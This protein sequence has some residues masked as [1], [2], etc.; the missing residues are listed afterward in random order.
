M[1]HRRPKA[2]SEMTLLVRMRH[3]VISP[4][5]T[6]CCLRRPLAAGRSSWCRKRLPRRR[7][8]RLQRPSFHKLA[9]RRTQRQTARRLRLRRRDGLRNCPRELSRCVKGLHRWTTRRS[10]RHRACPPHRTSSVRR[11]SCCRWRCRGGKPPAGSRKLASLETHGL[12]F[13]GALGGKAVEVP[14][15]RNRP[16]GERGTHPPHCALGGGVGPQPGS[17]VRTSGPRDVVRILGSTF[18]RRVGGSMDS[19]VWIRDAAT[20]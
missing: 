16:E 19:A 14:G 17:V 18:L 12:N 8:H 1:F 13:A 6:F 10:R 9:V 2:C 5:W 3:R 11:R 20:T 7:C 15:L 4:V